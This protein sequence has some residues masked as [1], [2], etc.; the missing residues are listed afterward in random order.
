MER[1]S[2]VASQGRS[3]ICYITLTITVTMAMYI[4]HTNNL[5]YRHKR[6]W[7]KD[8]IFPLISKITILYLFGSFGSCMRT[9]GR[10]KC[11][12]VLHFE[13]SSLNS[14]S[15]TET[16]EVSWIKERVLIR[17]IQGWIIFSNVFFS[18][19]IFFLFRARFP[20]LSGQGKSSLQSWQW[21]LVDHVL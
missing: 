10:K 9:A 18:K 14:T 2:S 15:T 19:R 7:R 11:S 4:F 16:S 20:F 3:Y 6:T 12:K 1:V 21:Y 8:I 5:S 13:K 17:T